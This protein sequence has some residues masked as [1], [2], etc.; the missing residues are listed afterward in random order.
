VAKVV[1]GEIMPDLIRSIVFGHDNRLSGVVAMFVLSLIALGCTCGKDFN[2]GNVSSN[3]SNTSSGNNIFGDSDDDSGDVDDALAKATIKSTTAKFANAI[4]TEDFSGLYA[5]TA[6]EFRS[7]YSEEELKNQF[8]D[9]IR[10]KRQLLPILATAVAMDPE[11]TDGPDTRTEGTETVL[12]VSGKYP[13]KPLPMTFKYEY[14]KR[15]SKW[16]LLRLEVYV[17]N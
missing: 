14:V 9:F 12:S 16:W 3:S 6:T 4:S 7:R 5:D 13:T 17:K 8:S 2:L 11:F 1:K 10:Q 15:Q